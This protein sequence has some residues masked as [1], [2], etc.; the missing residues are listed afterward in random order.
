MRLSVTELNNQIKAIVE[1]H[2]ELIEVEAEISQVTY[3]HTGHI[4]FSIK[5]EGSTLNCAMWKSNANRLKFKLEAGQKVVIYGALSVY[6]PRGEYKLIASK[7]TP[8]GVG[9]LQFAY[10]QLKK[11]LLQKGYFNEENKKIL[12]KYPKKVAIITAIPSA[13]LSD[14][15][16]IASKRWSLVKFYLYNS[17]MQGENAKFSVVENLKKAD[18]E[19]YDVIVIARGGGSLEDLWTFNTLE[20]ANAIF[21]AK[22]PIIS[23]I[24]HE[25]DVLISDYVA[26]KR[27]STPSNAMEILL[28]DINE[29]FFMLD[30]LK[31]Q[32]DN[33]ISHILH[34]KEQELINLKKL[35]Q[36]NSIE[37]EFKNKFEELRLIK[38]Q[39]NN[40]ISSTIERNVIMLNSMQKNFEQ[41]IIYLINKKENEL[42]NLKNQ[43]N[44]N[45]PE[46]K[47]K[48]GFVEISK[49]GKRVLLNELKK[50]DIIKLND[51]KIQRSAIIS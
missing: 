21:E 26:D 9:D 16:K 20:V 44:L 51:T 48:K 33:K 40:K 35:Y 42:N 47:E 13:A 50:G 45:N 11:E 39:F 30:D 14:M 10:E 49:N 2:F 22:T 18:K 3:H 17:L 41:Q 34:K 32:F 36:I 46:K 24:G 31:K 38:M 5:D 12:P 25:V 15:L 43:Y 6:T 4:Y 27:A 19:N 37:N 8:A 7:I 28:P 1:S 29:H 23:A